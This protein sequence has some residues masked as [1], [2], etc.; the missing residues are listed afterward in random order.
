M[1]QK[2]GSKSINK[3]NFSHRSLFKGTLNQPLEIAQNHKD[4][5]MADKPNKILIDNKF[6]LSEDDVE[7]VSA[8]FDV[9]IIENESEIPAGVKD[10]STDDVTADSYSASRTI[11][12]YVKGGA[13]ELTPQGIDKCYDNAQ[14]AHTKG[15]PEAVSDRNAQFY[16]YRK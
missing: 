11:S 12:E 6:L 15:I 8:L 10:M 1:K 5:K 4:K 14:Y 7:S 3:L 13:I 2:I 16:S 9:K